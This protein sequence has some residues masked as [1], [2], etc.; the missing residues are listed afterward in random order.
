MKIMV[1]NY[2]LF[3]F[4]AFTNLKV[5]S[6]FNKTPSDFIGFCGLYNINHVPKSLPFGSLYK[7]QI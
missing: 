5:P 7:N 2:F 1:N 6:G 3:D 4:V